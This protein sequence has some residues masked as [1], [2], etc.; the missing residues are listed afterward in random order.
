MMPVR[1]FQTKKGLMTTTQ[2]FNDSDFKNIIRIAKNT[3]YDR[4]VKKGWDFE[5]ALVTPPIDGMALSHL[6]MSWRRKN[7][8]HFLGLRKNKDADVRV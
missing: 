7:K 4:V 1:K 6:R 8:E 5:K 2:I 3:F